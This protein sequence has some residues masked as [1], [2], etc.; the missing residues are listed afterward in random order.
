M[1]VRNVKSSRHKVGEAKMKD[2]RSH[3]LT[4]VTMVRHSAE[5]QVLI[6]FLCRLIFYWREVCVC[7]C[8]QVVYGSEDNTL[9]L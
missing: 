9:K 6:S 4:G 5:D 8:V 7:V 1:N 3:Q 2:V